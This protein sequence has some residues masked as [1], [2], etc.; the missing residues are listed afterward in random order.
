MWHRF[1]PKTGRRTRNEI[2]KKR[3]GYYLPVC[4]TDQGGNPCGHERNRAGDKGLTDKGNRGER[5]PK[6]GKDTG[7][8]VQ[9]VCCR[10]KSPVPC[11][12]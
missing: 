9:P 12:A 4:R 3:A 2:F 7:A 5:H 10:H 1:L 6:T 8:G 11:R